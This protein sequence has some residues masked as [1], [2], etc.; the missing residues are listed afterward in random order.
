MKTQHLVFG[1]AILILALSACRD[2]TVRTTV[3]SDGSFTRLITVSGDSTDAFKKELPYP[4]DTSWTMTSKKDPTG[5]GKFIVTYSKQYK[6]C[7]ALKTELGRDTS[8]LRQLVRPIEIRKKFGFFYS[9][10]EY[11]ETYAAAN[12]FTVLPYKAYITPDDFLWLTRKNPIQR[13]ADSIRSKAAEDKLMKYLLESAIAEVEKILETGI[14]KLN[15]PTLDAK[16]V[17]E[18]HEKI[19]TAVSQWNYKDSGVMIDSLRL[20][21]GNP[22]ADRLKE[23]Q[24]PLFQEFNKKARF[25]ENLLTLEDFHVE[26]ALPGLITGTNSSVLNGNRVTWEVFPMAFLLES[27]VINV[28]AFVLA[29]IIVL[30]LLCLLTLRSLRR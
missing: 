7:E 1:L 8:W 6:D 25:L 2:I 24:P 20:W 18:F 3:N 27:R 4:V 16:R 10:I 21:T 19:R 30:A 28:W 23:I 15:D 26:T 17:K 12:P 5:K 9:Y 29:G 13:P 11:K 14:R 22:A